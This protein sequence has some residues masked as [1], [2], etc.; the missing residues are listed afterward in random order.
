M[1]KVYNAL[2]AILDKRE[3]TRY[4]CIAAYDNSSFHRG[5]GSGLNHAFY[6]SDY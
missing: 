1:I 3:K 5:V 4:I 6:G 2:V